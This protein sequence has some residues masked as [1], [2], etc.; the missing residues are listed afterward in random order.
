MWKHGTTK[1]GTIRWYCK[2]C[3]KSG[4]KKRIDVAFRYWENVVRRWLIEGL[5]LRTIAK[6]KNFHLRYVQTKC[7]EVLAR[8]VV[9]NHSTVLDPTKPLILDGTWILWRRL[10]VLIASDTERVVHWKFVPTENLNS[11]YSFLCEI[12]G[13]PRGVVSDAQKG[14]L[15]AV[16]LRFGDIPHQR[17]IAHIVRQSRL[18]LTRHP[19]TEAGVE[20]LALVNTLTDA[21]TAESVQTWCDTYQTWTERWQEFLKERSYLEGTNRWWYTH[22]KLRGVRSLIAN[23]LPNLFIHTTHDIPNTSNAL[24]GGLNG[25]LKF[26]FKEHRGLSVEHKKA[27]VNLFLSERVGK[28]NQH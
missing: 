20:L 19:K 28:K 7:A 10:V 24:E 1:A 15:G 8:V 22:R 26:V 16:L 21:R 11:W 14:L 6:E 23:A 18:W 9:L 5:K 27:L 3:K 12:Q 4:I 25:P 13:Q 2:T 17:C